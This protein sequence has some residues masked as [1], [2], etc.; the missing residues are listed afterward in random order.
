MALYSRIHAKVRKIKWFYEQTQ[1]YI[2]SG[3]HVLLT[4]QVLDQKLDLLNF[5]NLVPKELK[6]V[7][8]TARLKYNEVQQPR[9]AT[10]NN[11]YGGGGG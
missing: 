10:N 1:N 4:K 11:N 3:S 7:H 2:V 6:V 8:K 9:L 5:G